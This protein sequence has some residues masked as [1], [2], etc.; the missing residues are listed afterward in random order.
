MK[1]F[2]ADAVCRLLDYGGCI[3]A[4]RAAMIA[5]SEDEREQPLRSISTIAPQKL[6]GMMPGMLPGLTEFGAKLVSVFPTP[7]RPGRAAHQGLVVLF[8][9]DDGSVSCVA[10]AGAVT[11]IRT[12]CASAAAT[13]SL[14]LRDARQLGIFGCGAQARSHI[15]ALVR[16][17][18]FEEIGIWGRDIEAASRLADWAGEH[19]RIEARAYRDAETLAAKADVICTVTSASEPIIAADWIRPGTHLNLVGSSYAG[20]REV[21]STL[22]AK[23]RFFVDYRRSALAA[24]A[25][26]LKARDE[27]L[28]TDEHIAGE[29]GDV[30]AG[31]IAGRRSDEDITVYKSLG[32]VAQDLAAAR[33]LL[34]RADSEREADT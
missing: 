25:E 4:V 24:A 9:G 18:D 32:H 16:V 22:V 27:G 11:E 28:L 30:L 20:P 3:E 1:V 23:S 29:I 31:R 19:A 12:G 17:R 15:K 6:F 7:G 5:L 34:A 2:T 14:A 33:Y 26:F 10:D 8:D 13:D 21:D